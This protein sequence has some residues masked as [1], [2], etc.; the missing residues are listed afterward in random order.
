MSDLAS[1]PS[2]QK[3][4]T[5]ISPTYE[6]FYTFFGSRA[7]ARRELFGGKTTFKMAFYV[8]GGISFEFPEGGIAPFSQFRMRGDTLNRVGNPIFDSQSLHNQLSAGPQSSHK[9]VAQLLQV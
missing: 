2:S 6:I 9:S 7:F 4:G 5:N 8:D 1:P 3:K